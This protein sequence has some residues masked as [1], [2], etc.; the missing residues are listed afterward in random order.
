MNEDR[1]CIYVG[2]VFL[3]VYY[4]I[5][6]FLCTCKRLEEGKNIFY[7]YELGTKKY[8]DGIMFKKGFY[9]SPSKNPYIV[10]E[11]NCFSKSKY[12]VT[13]TKD[14]PG[15]NGI[16]YYLPI[17]I[18]YNSKIFL[19]AKRRGIKNPIFGTFFARL[20]MREEYY[21]KYFIG[22]LPEPKKPGKYRKIE[23]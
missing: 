14:Y 17:E 16:D 1:G 22:G 6:I 2:N 4:G 13:A 12:K 3:L 15:A 7:I 10:L 19:E 11:N 20:L 21:N 5:Y 23:A 9:K 18:D 8:K